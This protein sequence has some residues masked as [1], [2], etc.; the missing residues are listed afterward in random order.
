MESLSIV[1][2]A[3]YIVA[4]MSYVLKAAGRLG[5]N[6]DADVTLGAIAPILLIAAWGLMRL[7]RKRIER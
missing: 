3:Y 7:V 6:I 2:I 1:A 5:L 4:L